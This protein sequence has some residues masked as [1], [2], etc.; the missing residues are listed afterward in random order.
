MVRD[1]HGDGGAGGQSYSRHLRDYAVLLEYQ[2]LRTLAPPGVYVLPSP[3]N[4]RVW[5]GV[6][7]VRHGHYQRGVFKFVMELPDSYPERAPRV[8]FLSSVYHPVRSI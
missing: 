1:A 8:T 7:F 3:A 2:K 6:I 5:D 4:I